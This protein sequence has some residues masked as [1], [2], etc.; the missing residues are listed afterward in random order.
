MKSQFVK[1]TPSQNGIEQDQETPTHSWSPVNL[2]GDLAPAQSPGGNQMGRQESQRKGLLSGGQ[3]VPSLNPISG[4]GAIA[5]QDTVLQPAVSMTEP[6]QGNQA[7]YQPMD[8]RTSPVSPHESGMTPLSTFQMGVAQQSPALP[9]GWPVAPMQQQSPIAPGWSP[10]VNAGQPVNAAGVPWQPMP[11]NVQNLPP[12]MPPMPPMPQMQQQPFHAQPPLRKKKKKVPVWARVAIAGFVVMLVL[13]GSGIGYYEVNFAGHL[14]NI[15]GQKAAVITV[16]NKDGS[17]QSSVSAG[18]ASIGTNR[19]NILLLGSDNDA[20]FSAPLAQTDIIVTI[21]PQTKYVG[22]LSIPRDL[23]LNVPGIGMHKL[24][25]AFAEGWQYVHQGP[26]PFSNAVGLSILTIEQDFGIHIDHYAWVGLDGFIK[27]IDTAGGVD[28]NVTHPMVD[29]T[30][31]NDIQTANAYSYKRLYIPAGPQHMNGIQALEYVRTRH[32][33]LVGDFGRSARQ[34]QVLSQLKTKLDTPGIINDL[35]QL[36]QAL[37]GYVKTDMDIPTLVNLMTYARNFDP[38]TV[39]HIVLSPPYSSS[40]TA[41]NGED[42]FLPIC[43]K[44]TPAIAQMFN[45]TPVCNVTANSGNVPTLAATTPSAA[46]QATA[47]NANQLQDLG[48]I[49]TMSLSSSTSDPFGMRS[50]LDM[51]FMTVF[52]SF[53]AVKV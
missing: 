17:T 28:I 45:I 46:T 34:Q 44:I 2:Q 33:D 30:Y 16:K 31:P 14:S 50:I 32:S 10:F 37:D 51:M 15:T 21:D 9:A 7:Y 35:P 41:P 43:S 3:Y 22:M 8:Y 40:Y 23:W 25:E 27:V 39:A 36:A 13:L 29:D 38:N 5:A 48:Q 18:N 47:V 49:G 6:Y 4:P 11:G 12:Q 24:D 52:E 26:T 53:D 19:I 1:V 20:K 42:A